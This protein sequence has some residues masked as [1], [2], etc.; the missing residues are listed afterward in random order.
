MFRKY[1]E[2]DISSISDSPEWEEVEAAAGTDVQEEETALTVN[3]AYGDFPDAVQGVRY[4]YSDPSP[5]SASSA[6]VSGTIEFGDNS[7]DLSEFPALR[8]AIGAEEPEEPEITMPETVYVSEEERISDLV[9]YY[10]GLDDEAAEE[11]PE[12]PDAP[13]EEIPELFRAAARGEDYPVQQTEEEYREDFT[14]ESELALQREI[15][16][17]L[18]DYIDTIRTSAEELIRDR[19]LDYARV[20]TGKEYDPYNL[21]FNNRYD[22]TEEVLRE[23]PEISLLPKYKLEN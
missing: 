16:G 21:S 8:M 10:A 15:S 18:F 4:Y 22:D 1:R 11:S 6:A 9:S 7:V 2:T 20:K 13:Q 19:D 3:V 12:L 14:M 5:F 23:T 17:E